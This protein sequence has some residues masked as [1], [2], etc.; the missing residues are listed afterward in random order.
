MTAVAAAPEVLGSFFSDLHLG[1][2]EFSVLVEVHAVV[3]RRRRR[4]RD[5]ADVV[6][7][8]ERALERLGQP[9]G[10]ASSFPGR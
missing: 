10:R 9:G 1:Y 8:S 3:G 6:C 5:V 4:R 7:G 2:H